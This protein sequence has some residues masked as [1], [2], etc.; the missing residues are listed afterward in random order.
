MLFRSGIA[1]SA[2]GNGLVLPYLF[3]YLHEERKISSLLTG[4][5]AA[6]GGVIALIATPL[7]GTLIDHWG[8]K[9]TLFLGLVVNFFGFIYLAQVR[10]F[11]QAL[12][13]IFIEAVGGIAMWPAQ[14]A[15]ALQHVDEKHREKFF[16]TQFA[17]LNLGIGIGGVI[18]SL[19][20]NLHR[21]SSFQWLYRLDATT[22]IIYLIVVL[23]VG[24][25][26]L[27]KES[28]SSEKLVGPK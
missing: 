19:I 8:T 21:T 7:M 1:P 14:S 5:L 26:L 10:N 3:I 16:A 27:K 15:L 11:W 28:D 6:F 24:A 13:A 9:K 2:I 4:V 23:P 17:S 25:K 20:V 12:I 18:S 22:F